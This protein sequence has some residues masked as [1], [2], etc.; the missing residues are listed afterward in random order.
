MS[1]R[2]HELRELVGEGMGEFTLLGCRYLAYDTHTLQVVE[3]FC[4]AGLAR[5]MRKT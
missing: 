3:T 2:T 1:R 5:E 4:R